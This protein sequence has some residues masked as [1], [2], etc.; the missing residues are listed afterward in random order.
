MKLVSLKTAYAFKE[1]FSHENVRKQ[2][3]SNVLGIPS[4]SI[5]TVRNI[6]ICLKSTSLSWGSDGSIAGIEPK[7][8]T[9]AFEGVLTDVKSGRNK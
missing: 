4:E 3:P 5:R 8:E 9:N 2:F 7:A 1:A 6:R